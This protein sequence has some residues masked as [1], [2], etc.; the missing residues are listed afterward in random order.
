MGLTAS[1]GLKRFLLH[2]CLGNE[3]WRGA[4]HHP[5]TRILFNFII[6]C[7]QCC[8]IYNLTGTSYIMDSVSDGPWSLTG[9]NLHGR[10]WWPSRTQGLRLV[11]VFEAKPF[12]SIQYTKM[13]MEKNLC[14]Q[15]NKNY[16]KDIS[17]LVSLLVSSL[18]LPLVYSH[19]SKRS[20]SIFVT[21][22]AIYMS[23]QSW[24]CLLNRENRCEQYELP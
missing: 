21:L 7:T 23:L 16:Q 1:A 18:V 17:L 11:P 4:P 19:P 8:H 13:Q 6:S 22:L 3:S 2:F 24:L 10:K 20:Y 14:Q 5:V 12:V 15:A 9:C